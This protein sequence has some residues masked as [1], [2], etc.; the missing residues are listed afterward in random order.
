MLIKK[1][2]TQFVNFCTTMECSE[3]ISLPVLTEYDASMYAHKL[4]KNFLLKM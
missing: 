2:Q 4:H 3:I 1:Q